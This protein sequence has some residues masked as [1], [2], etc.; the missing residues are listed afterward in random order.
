ML[1][2]LKLLQNTKSRKLYASLTLEALLELLSMTGGASVE[3]KDAGEEV[4]ELTN[5][6]AMGAKMNNCL[7]FVHSP[8]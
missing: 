1:K 8:D 2:Y 3:R 5:E 7:V 6:L 4:R